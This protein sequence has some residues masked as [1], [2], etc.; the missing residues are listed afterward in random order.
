MDSVDLQKQEAMKDEL[1]V[2]IEDMDLIYKRPSNSLNLTSVLKEQGKSLE[3]NS[4]VQVV[5]KEDPVIEVLY[6]DFI[7]G[8]QQRV[9]KD[10]VQIVQI[11]EF[12]DCVKIVQIEEL[13]NQS[14]QACVQAKSDHQTKQYLKSSWSKRLSEAYKPCQ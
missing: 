6:I 10:C 5:L 11:E 2:K 9:F 3:Y 14:V 7:F 8:N 1:Q 12:K 4:I 13:Q